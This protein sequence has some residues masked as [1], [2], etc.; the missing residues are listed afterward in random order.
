MKKLLQLNKPLYMADKVTLSYETIASL[1]VL[2]LLV[3]KTRG[4]NRY[5]YILR[6]VVQGVDSEY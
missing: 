5:S 6:G 3:L 4:M 2:S 1:F